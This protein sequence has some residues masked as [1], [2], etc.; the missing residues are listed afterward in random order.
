MKPNEQLIANLTEFC[1]KKSFKSLERDAP[2]LGVLGKII[3]NSNLSERQKL[4]LGHRMRY[5]ERM[6]CLEPGS[7]E[8]LE[9][10]VD[11]VGTFE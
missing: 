3:E 4:Q 11:L 8:W 10:I 5:F 7:K 9:K 1:E 6:S 2:G